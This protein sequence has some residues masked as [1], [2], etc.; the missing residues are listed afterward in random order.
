MKDKHNDN[1]LFLNFGALK[2]QAPDTEGALEAELRHL[3]ETLRA[4][5]PLK[6]T[7]GES[8]RVLNN[9]DLRLG[10]YQR[11]AVTF[12]NY[13]YRLAAV[14]A[15]LF[16]VVM[17]ATLTLF[18]MPAVTEQSTTVTMA[19]DDSDSATAADTLDETYVYLLVNDYVQSQGYGSGETLLGE[20][21][22]EE[23]T[24]LEKNLKFGDSR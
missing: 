23:L 6:M 20:L 14:T 16:L 4:E 2:P 15:A 22:D 5:T 9:L 8:R 17:T 11:R 13:S 21:G 24:Y 1:N 12:Y 18:D 19:T 7:D 10:R 3:Q